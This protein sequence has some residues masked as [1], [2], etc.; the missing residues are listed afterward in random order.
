MKKN[1]FETSQRFNPPSPHRLH[2]RTPNRRNPY[3]ITM[4]FHNFRGVAHVEGPL[5]FA[6]SMIH[7]LFFM[8]YSIFSSRYE[9]NS[10]QGFV[11]LTA[12]SLVTDV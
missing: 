1:D 5:I 9:S 7:V 2:S 6:T 12:S 8:R 10:C 3:P 11:T 4:T